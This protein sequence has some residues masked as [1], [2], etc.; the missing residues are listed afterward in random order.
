MCDP[1]QWSRRQRIGQQVRSCGARWLTCAR[2]LWDRGAVE[3]RRS[4]AAAVAQPYFYLSIS[5]IGACSISHVT[6]STR[7]RLSRPS[8]IPVD[9]RETAL[10]FVCKFTRLRPTDEW[11]TDT[12]QSVCYRARSATISLRYCIIV[13]RWRNV[14]WLT[15]QF[16][17]RWT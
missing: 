3:A 7:D 6:V 12:I 9:A 8:L 13:Q 17:V 5:V 11:C 16:V 2:A 15:I 4:S 10:V 1:L 14:S